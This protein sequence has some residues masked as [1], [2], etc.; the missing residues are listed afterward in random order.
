MEE[1]FDTSP[2]DDDWVASIQHRPHA[3]RSGDP[4]ASEGTDP[5]AFR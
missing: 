3:A 4:A 2:W 1:H 5:A